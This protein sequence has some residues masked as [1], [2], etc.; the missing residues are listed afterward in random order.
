MVKHREI[1]EALTSPKPLKTEAEIFETESFSSWDVEEM[2]DEDLF[3]LLPK[4]KYNRGKSLLE[5]W[6]ATFLPDGQPPLIFVRFILSFLC[7]C[8]NSMASAHVILKEIRH[9]LMVAVSREK[10][11]TR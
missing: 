5:L 4:G 11:G 8:S 7:M 10:N 3:K 2:K 1:S 9:R 6:I